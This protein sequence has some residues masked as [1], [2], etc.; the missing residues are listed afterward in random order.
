MEPNKTSPDSPTSGSMPD[1]NSQPS[2]EP[3]VITPSSD[4]EFRAGQPAPSS[5]Q[6]QLNPNEAVVGS[7]EPPNTPVVGQPQPNIVSHS[8][9]SKLGGLGGTSKKKLL[10]GG[11]ITLLV[12][13][14]SLGYVFGFYLP[15]KPANVYQTGLDRSGE[16]LNKL[17]EKITDKNQ[18]EKIQNS[19]IIATAE[20]KS[21]GSTF[22]GTFAVKQDKTKGDGSLDIKVNTEGEERALNVKFLSELLENK[23]YPNYYFQVNGIK[24]L[25]LGSFLPGLDDYEGKWIAVES[26]YLESIF[27]DQDAP[28]NTENVTAE[29]VASLVRTV[30]STTNEYLLTS[31]KKKA[32]LE[33]RAYIGRE[34][35]D[36]IKTHRYKVG[37]N[38][39]HAKQFCK[40]LSERMISH[41]AYK[42]LANMDDKAVE[43]QKKD[44]A[45]NCDADIDQEIKDDMTMDLWI[46]AKYKLVHKLRIYDE[47]NKNN[48]ADIGQKYTGGDNISFFIA[49]HDEAD[50][51]D[52]KLTVDVDTKAYTSKGTFTWVEKKEEGLEAKI[53]FE[54]KPYDGEVKVAKPAGAI[55]IQEVMQKFGFEPPQTSPPSGNVQLKAKDAERQSDIRALQSQLEVY[56]AENGFY[57]SLTNVNSTSWRASNMRGLDKE[58]LKDPDG[59]ATTLAT[60]ATAKQYGYKPTGCAAGGNECQAFSLTAILSTGTPFTKNSLN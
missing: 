25:G 47:N 14:G 33:N 16:N 45:K 24:A 56:Y 28:K 20:A 1:G 41:P 43:E 9:N 35:S 22:S 46:D 21:A 55:G 23:K 32:V 15:N 50:K 39:P 54:A 26:D 57:P 18:L 17:V 29:E 34:T 27:T 5:G 40:V 59:T 19:Q 31:D 36:G 2:Q 6:P 37:V 60:T 10:L 3:T 48:Y 11:L 30:S 38:K 49:Y 8:Q 51:T 52:A 44:T 13:G 7:V 53:T 42:K 58:A 12:I 4:N